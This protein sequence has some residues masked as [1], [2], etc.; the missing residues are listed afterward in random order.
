MATINITSASRVPPAIRSGRRL[1]LFNPYNPL[2]HANYISMLQIALGNIRSNIVSRPACCQSCD[3]AFRHLPRGRS[4][5]EVFNNP[6]VWINFDPRMDEQDYASTHPHLPDITITAACFQYAST[7][8]RRGMRVLMGTIVH[9]MAH[10]NGAH[11]SDNSAESTLQSCC[12]R[13]VYDAD[14]VG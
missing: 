8:G 9:E 3:D 4:F 2:T 5:R 6:N 11:S 10:I 13:D 12:L 1:H 14:Y 7:H